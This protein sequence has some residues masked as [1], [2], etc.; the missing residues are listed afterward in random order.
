MRPTALATTPP[1]EVVMRIFTALK[2][3][4]PLLDLNP[5]TLG[6][7]ASTLTITS[8]TRLINFFAFLFKFAFY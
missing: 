3:L 2:N 5:R 6:P 4:S 7:L 8:P 1:K